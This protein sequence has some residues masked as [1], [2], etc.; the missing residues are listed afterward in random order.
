MGLTSSHN[1]LYDHDSIY[2]DFINHKITPDNINDF[3]R[4]VNTNE[5]Q[6][7]ENFILNNSLPTLR[8]YVIDDS[9]ENKYLVP[10]CLQNT[11]DFTTICVI[12]SLKWL[13]FYH[14]I[15]ESDD[16]SIY[17]NEA[18]EKDREYLHTIFEH[19][20]NFNYGTLILLI[21]HNNFECLKYLVEKGYPL[22]ANVSTTAAKNNRLDILE[23][24]YYKNCPIDKNTRAM[25]NKHKD[26]KCLT[27]LINKRCPY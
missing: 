12:G 2:N 21:E 17:I 26:N 19:N 7:V 11:I 18:L 25:A 6:D 24:L 16:K 10:Y 14:Q 3:I 15:L 22:H 9:I 20:F 27:F 4:F 1:L 5:I 8:R 23:Y 13:K